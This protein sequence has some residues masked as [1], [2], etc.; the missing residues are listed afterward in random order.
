[1]YTDTL[2]LEGVKVLDLTHRLPGP[3]SGLVLSQFGAEVIKVEDAVFKDAFI[4]GLF[5]QMDRLCFADWYKELNKGKEILRWDFKAH[6]TIEKMQTLADQ[7][8]LILMGL[9]TKLQEKFGL[10]EKSLI[11]RGGA[12]ALI[13]LGASKVGAKAMHDINAMTDAGMMDLYLAGAQDDIVAPPFLPLSGIL[14]GMNL[15]LAGLSA[16]LKAREKKTLISDRVYIFESAQGLLH[17]FWSDQ[18]KLSG[19]KRFL[20][21]GAFPC[22]C[23]YRTADKQYVA[24]AAVEEKFWLSFVETFGVKMSLEERFESKREHFEY[25]AQVFGKLKLAEVKKLAEGKEMCLS[26]VEL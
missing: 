8:D 23:F 25:L 21:N 12:K 10:D 14:Y 3:F 6:E 9:P 16:L 18:L 13:S 11:A 1:M 15:A 2:L 24:L 26:L 19:R 4:Y 7:S 17:P 22:Y 20:H 5:E